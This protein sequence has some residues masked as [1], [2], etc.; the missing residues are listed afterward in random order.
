MVMNMFIDPYNF[1][2]LSSGIDFL[3]AQTRQDKSGC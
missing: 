3:I 2:Y 1:K